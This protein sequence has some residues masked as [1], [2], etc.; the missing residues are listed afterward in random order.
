MNIEYALAILDLY[1]SVS[2]VQRKVMYLSAVL[3]AAA[4]EGATALVPSS[5]GGRTGRELASSHQPPG[6]SNHKST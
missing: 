2:P 5:D 3:T 6:Q 1:R 4:N